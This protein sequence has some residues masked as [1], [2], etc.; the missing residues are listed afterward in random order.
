MPGFLLWTIWKERNR[1]VD[2]NEKPSARDL[3]ILKCFQLEASHIIT[4]PRHQQQPNSE[5]NRWNCPPEGVLKLNFDGASRGNPGRAS[6][7]GVIRNQEA[8]IVHI[9]C[10][11]LGEGTNNEMEFAALEQG[12]RILKSLQNSN[13]V[14]EGDSSLVISVA[15]KIQGGTQAC[16]ATRHWRLAK[17]TENIAQLIGEMKG[18]V[19]QT[20]RR[21][22]NGLA[23]YLA[24]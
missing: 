7:G 16:K 3:H 12:L 24:N 14:V 19:F 11:A 23:D 5:V 6:I 13:A 4:T 18:L 1:R 15:K 9:Y 17:V 10:R 2:P 8:E 21:K 22:A 20:V